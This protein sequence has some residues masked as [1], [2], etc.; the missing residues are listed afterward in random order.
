MPTNR[1]AGSRG[2]TM[3][4]CSFG[5][6][7]VPSCGPPIHALYRGSSFNPETG[8]HV[9]PPSSDRK[10]PWGEVPA[11]HVPASLAWPGVSQ[12]V[13]STARPLSLSGAFANAGGRFASFQLRP[14]SVERNTVGPR[15]P[16]FAAA[17]SVRPSRGS[18]TRWL[19]TWPRKW[20]PSTRHLLR[21]PSPWKSQAP[22]RVETR[23]TSRAD[24]AV[25]VIRVPGLFVVGIGGPPLRSRSRDVGHRPRAQRTRR[26]DPIGGGPL[27]RRANDRNAD[28]A[29]II[30]PSA[31]RYLREHSV[32]A[33][34]SR[35]AFDQR[36]PPQPTPE[37]RSPQGD[38]GSDVRA[39]EA[40]GRTRCG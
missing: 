19:I 40:G 3:I 9:T 10:R 21:A 20:G 4:E 28:A 18:R 13:W 5:P 22:F 32:G 23:R 35:S 2:S 30:E 15:W 16:V 26:K 36:A 39:L 37:P 17:R 29:R 25:R 12:N 11:Y 27:R 34:V 38:R 8:C 6:S 7:G 31:A 1:C 33:N 24:P 14:R